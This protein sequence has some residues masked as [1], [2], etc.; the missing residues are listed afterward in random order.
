MHPR[1]DRPERV[2]AL[3]WRYCDGRVVAS[4]EAGAEYRG[5]EAP[6]GDPDV[7]ELRRGWRADRGE[8]LSLTG[9][10]VPLGRV[11]GE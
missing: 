7:E 4:D 8:H 2:L 9:C 3:A 1:D 5:C 11:V 10:V 6:A